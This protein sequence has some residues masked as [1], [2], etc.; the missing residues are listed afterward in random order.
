MGSGDR[1]TILSRVHAPRSP[2]KTRTAASTDNETETTLHT[3]AK[4]QPTPTDPASTTLILTVYIFRGEPTDTYNHRHALLYLTSPTLPHYHETIH[5]QRDEA[6]DLWVVDR[7]HERVAW[8]EARAYVGH[9]SA[10]ALRVPAGREMEPVEAIAGV[11]AGARPPDWNCQNFLYEGFQVLVDRGWQTQE[12]WD[13][14]VG[15]MM[16]RLLDATV[17]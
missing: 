6:T 15:E 3:L 13:E 7:L 5:T 17:V 14:V 11:P 4:P 9:V 8:F 1:P 2:E 16:D 10:G 12:W